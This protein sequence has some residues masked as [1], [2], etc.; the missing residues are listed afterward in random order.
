MADSRSILGLTL[1][2]V[3]LAG[4]VHVCAQMNP[5]LRVGQIPGWNSYYLFVSGTAAT[6]F[7]LETSV[8][9]K[10]WEVVFQAFGWPGTNPVYRLTPQWQTNAQ[11]FWRAFPGE[12][13]A[14]QEQRWHEHEP[15]E[16]T[17][18]FRHMISFWEGGVQGTVRVRDGVV[19]AVTDARDDK[20]LEPVVQP[21]LSQ[22]LSIT[23]LFSEIRR[24]FEAGSEQV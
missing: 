19:V 17:Y 6:N 11:A 15:F 16:Y 9:L 12:T 13:L 10:T 1:G 14:M 2:V 7:V 22:F 21:D 5:I 23:Q 20:T 8:D 18:R 3:L 24:E 4:Q